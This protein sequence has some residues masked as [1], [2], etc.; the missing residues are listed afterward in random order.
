MGFRAVG[1]VNLVIPPVA[2]CN[3]F[4]L[5]IGYGIGNIEF[6]FGINRLAVLHQNGFILYRL[7]AD[8]GGVDRH[9]SFIVAGRNGYIDVLHPGNMVAPCVGF[10]VLKVSQHIGHD[11]VFGGSSRGHR[12]KAAGT[13]HVAG[14][15]FLIGQGGGSIDH[16]VRLAR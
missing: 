6:G 1:H 13:C 9:I 2:P 11:L 8:K 14:K 4:R 10:R 16:L 3:Q 7:G 12:I 5:G 15:E